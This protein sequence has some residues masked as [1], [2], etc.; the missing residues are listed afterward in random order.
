MHRRLVARQRVAELFGDA[1]ERAG[2]ASARRE[3]ADLGPVARERERASAVERLLDRPRAGGRVAVLVPADPAPEAKRRGRL[4]EHSPQVAD[5]RG[6]DVEQ[7]P[8]EEPEAMADLVDHARATRPDLVRLPER[9]HLLRER[10]LDRVPCRVGQR[11]VVEPVEQLVEADLRG[12][13]R[14]SR[15][16][17]RVGGEDELERDPPPGGR[18][19]SSAD[20]R[21][22]EPREGIGERF[23][24]RSLLVLVLTPAAQAVVL[25]RQ[26]GE[27]EVE[28]EGAERP[29]PAGRAARR[30]RR[31]R[32][33]RAR[34][35]SRSSVPAESASGCPP[36]RRA[37]LS[38]PARPARGRGCRRAGERL[39]A[40]ARPD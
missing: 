22:L 36:R 31:T 12:E 7:A 5:E 35:R 25:L 2:E 17:G 27:L 4:G 33:V 40:A 8:L 15:R 11:R 37:G 18:E 3:L 6:R 39:A 13:H 10:G 14:A 1:D 30:R 26:V 21:P 9:R 20:A 34:L 29:Q 23:P 16:L 24:R 38:R 19:A 28:G 32:A